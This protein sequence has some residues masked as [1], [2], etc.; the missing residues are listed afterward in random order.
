MFQRASHALGFYNYIRINQF[1]TFKWSSFTGIYATYSLFDIL[2]LIL[3]IWFSCLVQIGNNSNKF[4]KKLVYC[5]HVFPGCRHC[6][7]EPVIPQ[8][9]CLWNWNYESQPLFYVR[10]IILQ[11]TRYPPVEFT[12]Q[13]IIYSH[14]STNTPAH[15]S[16]VNSKQTGHGLKKNSTKANAVSWSAL[17]QRHE[18]GKMVNYAHKKNAT[19]CNIHSLSS[20]LSNFYRH[21]AIT[22]VA[23]AKR[24]YASCPHLPALD[25]S[26]NQLQFH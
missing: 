16:A 2:K 5:K 4:D 11:R 15:R 14:W 9:R 26:V 17:L 3:V 12:F 1:S 18:W 6:A 8:Y 21:H 22:L 7:K 13:K 20:Q 25:M 24:Q 23:V 19:Q 10:K